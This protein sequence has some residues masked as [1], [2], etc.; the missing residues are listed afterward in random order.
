MNEDWLEA[1]II[2]VSDE[3]IRV[4]IEEIGQRIFPRGDE[5]V[6]LQKGD[7]IEVLFKRHHN[8]VKARTFSGQT[9]WEQFG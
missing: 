7:W 1:Q 6:Q 4:E 2:E 3:E 9:I 5:S 8:V